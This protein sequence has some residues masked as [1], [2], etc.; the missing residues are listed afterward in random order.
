MELPYA[1]HAQVDQEKLTYYL[2]SRDHPDGRAKAE[3]FARFGFN[4]DEW[5]VFREALRRHGQVNRVVGEA[6]SR[7]G[8]RYIV[9]GPLA[10]P[11]GRTPRVRTV[12]ILETGARAPRLV[13]A[14]PVRGE[15]AEGT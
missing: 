7:F 14:Y 15:H 3:F 4:L 10:T 6:R 8:V 1:S 13:T 5:E 11:S 9:E 12:W 2:L